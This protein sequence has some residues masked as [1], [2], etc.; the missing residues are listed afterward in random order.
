MG[1]HFQTQPEPGE[2]GLRQLLPA[3]FISIHIPSVSSEVKY[4][5]TCPSAFLFIC[6]CAPG[7]VLSAGRPFDVRPKAI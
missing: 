6:E 3:I 5:P 4:F 7:C 2:M 1:Q